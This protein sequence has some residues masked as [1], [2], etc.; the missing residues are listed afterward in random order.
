MVREVYRLFIISRV[1]NDIRIFEQHSGVLL[2]RQLV[3]D[4]LLALVVQK[5]LLDLC[6]RNVRVKLVR[7]LDY[8]KLALLITGELQVAYA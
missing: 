5:Q 1:Q 7:Q 8:F 3:L 6:L 4:F 2:V